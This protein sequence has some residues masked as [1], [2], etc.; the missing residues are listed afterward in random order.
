M[1]ARS[2]KRLALFGIAAGLVAAVGLPAGLADVS[3]GDL[4]L[5]ARN[6]SAAPADRAAPVP[7]PTRTPV[8]ADRKPAGPPVVVKPGDKTAAPVPNPTR[9]PVGADRE[10][11]GPPVVVKPGDGDGTSKPAE[12]LPDPGQ[13]GIGGR[14][15]VR[16]VTATSVTST[17]DNKVATA[18][19]P[20]GTRIYGGGGQ[21]AINGVAPARESSI[22]LDS[23]RPATRNGADT[24]TATAKRRAVENEAIKSVD[25]SVK[26]VA[27]C[28]RDLPG[29]EHVVAQDGALDQ[30]VTATAT[31]PTGKRVIG[32]GGAVSDAFDMFS[33]DALTPDAGGTSVTV[34]GVD[35]TTDGVRAAFRNVQAIAV[36][37]TPPNGYEVVSRRLGFATPF[38]TFGACPSGKVAYSAGFS[39]QD[40]AGHAII[41]EAMLLRV[42]SD[43]SSTAP[44]T[45]RVTAQNIESLPENGV[46]ATS[47]CAS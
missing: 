46:T 5:V 20:A 38:V 1:K 10:P 41:S 11:A 18:T 35:D 15:G 28:G 3:V 19:C 34:S 14:G 17:D 8:G 2:V 39:K 7:N 9:T 42:D 27:V 45:A 44:D 12:P 25:W 16:F 36:C 31:C 37:A 26:A 6:S 40:E 22:M 24:F 30:R 43:P 29:Y 47:I 13:G 32:V 23:L 4:L 33:F 21:I